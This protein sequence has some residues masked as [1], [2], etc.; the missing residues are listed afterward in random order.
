MKSDIENHGKITRSLR[1]LREHNVF[2]AEL[3]AQKV[4]MCSVQ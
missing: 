2:H 4:S 1:T 3:C